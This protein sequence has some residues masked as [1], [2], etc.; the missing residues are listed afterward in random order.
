MGKQDIALKSYFKN[1]DRFADLINT[2]IYNGIQVVKPDD[3]EELDTDSSLYI[4]TQGMKIPLARV[5]DVIR[6]SAGD[7]EYVIYGVENQSSI[8]Y[9]MPL[10]VM[11]YDTLTYEAECRQFVNAGRNRKDS[12]YLSKMRKKDR[13][14]PVFTLVIYY[15]E[16]PWD[17]ARSLKDMMVDMPKWMEKRF[18]D[19]PMKLLEIGTCRNTFQNQD[20]FNFIKIIQLLYSDKVEELQRYY[21]NVKVGR[22]TAELVGTITENEEILNYVKEHKDEEE[23]NM[24]E[25]TKRWEQRWTRK[26]TDGFIN[27]MGVRK[28]GEENLA[29]EEAIERLE[30][31]GRIEGEKKGIAKEKMEIAQKMKKEGCS[32]ELIEK[33]TGILL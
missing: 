16:A 15:G 33:V 13:I 32:K 21:A 7:C 22:D 29:P 10:R 17:G 23:I 9:A 5:R 8:H 19:Y 31:K 6:K 26:I 4:H 11:M 20:I 2:G 1:N 28:E 30:S 27:M 14:H 25:A 18:N 24:C 3:L 12:E